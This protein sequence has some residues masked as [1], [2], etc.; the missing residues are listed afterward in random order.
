[1]SCKDKKYFL[2]KTKIND[3]IVLSELEKKILDRIIFKNTTK[4][5]PLDIQINKYAYKKFASITKN[6]KLIELLYAKYK[7]F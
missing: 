3:T 1:M 4:E 2:Q 5:N 6:N 7:C